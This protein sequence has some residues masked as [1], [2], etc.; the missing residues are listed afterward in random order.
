MRNARK[1]GAQ[2]RGNRRGFNYTVRADGRFIALVTTWWF[3]L[4]CGN[5]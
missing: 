5:G 1:D 3:W 4:G 2:M